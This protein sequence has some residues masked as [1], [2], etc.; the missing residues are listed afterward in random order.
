M[1]LQVAK[2]LEGKLNFAISAKDEFQH[3][4]NEY[5]IDF[6]KGE[7]PIVTARDSK[8]QKFILKEEFSYVKV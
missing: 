3:E 6:V 4:L 2:K 8:N 5:G 1:I 7:K